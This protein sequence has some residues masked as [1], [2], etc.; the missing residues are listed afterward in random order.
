[1]PLT[2]YIC[3]F[4]V[5]CSCFPELW[6]PG[7]LSTMWGQADT[8]GQWFS[9]PEWNRVVGGPE[10]LVL[11]LDIKSQTGSPC[12]LVTQGH[13]PLLFTWGLNKTPNVCCS[14][15]HFAP[16]TLAPSVS[17]SAFIVSQWIFFHGDPSPNHLV[18]KPHRKY[19]MSC[20]PC[21]I[22]SNVRTSWGIERY[23]KLT[24]TNFF[25]I[26]LHS[27]ISAV[28][29]SASCQRQNATRCKNEVIL[30]LA[31]NN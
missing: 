22:F 28:K 8:V 4:Y 5:Y 21:H 31:S 2:T 3:H 10:T 24:S 11:F 27:E 18:P 16:V 7:Y 20:Q 6:R 19:Q 12:K 1:M 14:S 26:I 17:Q 15:I 29:T 13:F 9:S 30:H 25:S 23:T